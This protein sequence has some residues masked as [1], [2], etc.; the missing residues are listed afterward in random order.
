MKKGSLEFEFATAGRII[1]GVGSFE[2]T[3]ELAA[4]IGTNAFIL[5][6]SSGR[7]T[8]E[9]SRR[10]GSAGLRT[11]V[12]HISGE[13]TT[14]RALAVVKDAR[15]FGADLVIAVGGG[16]VIDTGKAAA[17]LLTNKGDLFDYLEVIGKGK[18][19]TEPS[20]PF[21]AVPTTAGNRGRGH[22]ERRPSFSRAPGQSQHA[23]P[24]DAPPDWRWSIPL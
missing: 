22:P 16:S 7:H 8:G 14:E 17:A 18:K 13:P 15:R 12:S 5:T 3:A 9:L 4:K 24:P 19:I 11:A 23:Q 10:L 21:L 6:G 2:R 20:A 1:F